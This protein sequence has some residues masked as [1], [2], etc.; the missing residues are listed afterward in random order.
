MSHVDRFLAGTGA[1]SS[2]DRAFAWMGVAASSPPGHDNFMKSPFR[3]RSAIQ[4]SETQSPANPGTRTSS[5]QGDDH[6][7]PSQERGSGEHEPLT[8]SS[9]PMPCA[10]S[11]QVGADL[12]SVRSTLYPGLRDTDE[13]LD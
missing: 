9:E 11:L 3:M 2:L 4:D 6:E 1:D 13:R 5:H 12:S 7:T 8:A 10:I